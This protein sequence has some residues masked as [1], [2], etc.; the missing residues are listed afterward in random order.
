MTWQKPTTAE[1][2]FSVK[3]FAAAMLALYLAMRLGLPRPFWAPL[4]AYIVSQPMS[5]ATRSK[6]LYRMLGTIL[7]SIATVLLIPRLINYS[8]VLT[9]A[10]SAW[11]GI[12]LYISLLNRSP[13]A[14]IFMLAG[15]TP[16]FIGFPTLAADISTFS[17]LTMFDGAVARVEEILLGVACA[18]LIHSLFFP[19]SIGPV[20]LKR[21]DQ[22]L[23]DVKSWMRN[24][25][26]GSD[27]TKQ[28]IDHRKLAQ[29]VTELRLMSTHVP[30]DTS[31]LRWTANAIRVL[32]D[33]LAAVVPFM[34]AVEDRIRLLREAHAGQLPMQWQTLLEDIVVWTQQGV[35]STPESAIAL[36]RRIND[37]TPVVNDQSLWSSV[38]EVNLAAHLNKLIDTCEHCFHQRRQVGIA[39]DGKHP[40]DPQQIDRVPTRALHADRG[41]ALMSAAGAATALFASTL[42]WILSGWPLGFAAPTM[43]VLYCSFFASLDDPVPALKISL[44]YTLFSSFFA[45]LY[46]LFL[47]PSAHSFEMLM[48]SFAPFLLVGGIYLSRPAS[49][50]RAVPL[51]FTTMATLT[52]VD[53]GISDM[54]S[55]INSQISQAIGIGFAVLFTGLF[56]SVSTEWS[57]RRLLRAGWQEI[58]Q[59]TQAIRPPPVVAVTVRMVD[60]VSLLTPRL[61]ASRGLG[62]YAAANALQDLRIGV[63]M[64]HLLRVRTRLER[65]TVSIQSLVDALSDHF[66]NR[67]DDPA[68]REPSLLQKIDHTL[69]NI[70]R[71]PPFPMRNE[72]V[73][74]L[75]GIRRDLFP[76]AAPYQPAA[77]IKE[78]T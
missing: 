53:I 61:A 25:L 12:C 41:F 50:V 31:N 57:A 30:F 42:F 73:A 34:T 40:V 59:L 46:V 51:F 36:R 27:G 26:L 49:I 1:M 22:T 33:R 7:G 68:K 35:T 38:L 8:L 4:T 10:L 23:D 9:L 48:L 5:G 69:Q 13:R 17:P 2:L 65:H 29:D 64:T 44:T 60:R 74:A 20:I 78:T 45:G 70:C 55:F 11:L 14:Y 66:R 16:I 32:Q 71:T 37:L 67:P 47:L 56:R 18:T 54:T 58:V 62:D 52:M 19:Q 21:M 77:P 6:A 28:A 3:S 75:A 24:A 43:T 72:A 15:Y 76:E 39:L 63:N